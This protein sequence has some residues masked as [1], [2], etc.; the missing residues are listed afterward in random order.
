LEGGRDDLAAAPIFFLPT[1]KQINKKPFA[2][3]VKASFKS[4][5]EFLSEMFENSLKMY[6]AEGNIV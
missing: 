3:L 1:N 6:R 5:V 4:C 2:Q